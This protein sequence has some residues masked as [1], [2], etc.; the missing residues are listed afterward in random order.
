MAL[1]RTRLRR[2]AQAWV[3]ALNNHGDLDLVSSAVTPRG[4]V[5]RFVADEPDTAPQ[6]I[7]GV[8]VV[9]RWLASAPTKTR[10][11][12]VPGS[13]ELSAD[14][15]NAGLVRYRVKVGEFENFGTWTLTLAADGRIKRLEHR[16]DPVP[17][18]W[19]L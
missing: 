2:S 14:D 1:T 13:L 12:L 3:R 15:A 6:R 10:F 18:R 5:W 9:A 19:R 8:A 17:E 16:P 4:I 11:S 7:A